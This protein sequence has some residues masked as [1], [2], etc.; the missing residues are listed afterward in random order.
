MQIYSSLTCTTL[1]CLLVGRQPYDYCSCGDLCWEVA[2]S[3][4][5]TYKETFFYTHSVSVIFQISIE[6]HFLHIISVMS[7]SSAGFGGVKLYSAVIPVTTFHSLFKNPAQVLVHWLWATYALS[8]ALSPV[9]IHKHPPTP[10]SSRWRSSAC[11]NDLR[12]TIAGLTCQNV[13]MMMVMP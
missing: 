10:V 2:L 7:S 5:V 6:M 9:Q 12:S 1:V 8:G 3:S 4:F 13:I 11:Y